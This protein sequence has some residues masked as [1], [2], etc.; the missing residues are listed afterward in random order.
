[1]TPIIEGFRYVFIGK[2]ELYTNLLFYSIIT[3][4]TIF[5]L[6]FTIFNKVEKNFIDTV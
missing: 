3:T 6:G 4:L 5:L 1:M 2:G